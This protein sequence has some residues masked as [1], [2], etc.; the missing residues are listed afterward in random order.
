MA[1]T[2]LNIEF[3]RAS[4]LETKGTDFL[5]PNLFFTEFIFDDKVRNNLKTYTK[6][7]EMRKLFA[8]VKSVSLPERKI[9][10]IEYKR[11]GKTIQIPTTGEWETDVTVKFNL[12]DKRKVLTFLEYLFHY[13]Q[14]RRTGSQAT[15]NVWDKEEL[16]TPWSLVVYSVSRQW[17]LKDAK[18][19]TVDEDSDKFNF[20]NKW[21]AIASTIAANAVS[22]IPFA[23]DLG[24]ANWNN[25][26]S[27]AEK[28]NATGNIDQL[29][30]GYAQSFRN[31]FVKSISNVEFDYANNDQIAEVSVVF[32]F[33]DTLLGP[34]PYQTDVEIETLYPFVED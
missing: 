27:V 19:A 7:S 8:F 25:V 5:R 31:I 1:Y 10:T 29:A 24:L 30:S 33:S 17:L 12:D 26:D 3:L 32:G 20:I 18:D 22:S 15:K 4:I 13:S 34:L 16:A 2:P 6:F 21:S 9:E 28:A 23:T 11:M 14:N